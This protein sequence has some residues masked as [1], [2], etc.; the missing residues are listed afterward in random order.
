MNCSLR[1]TKTSRVVHNSVDPLRT[2]VAFGAQIGGLSPKTARRI[3]EHDGIPMY[4]IGR[5]LMLRQS[6]IDQWI[7]GKRLTAAHETN[8]MKDLVHRAV[9]RARKR[10]AS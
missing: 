9:E 8:P 5:S 3:A 2:L 1:R 6:D 7:E 4:R 10:R